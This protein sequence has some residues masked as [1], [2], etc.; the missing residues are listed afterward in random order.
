MMNIFNWARQ[1]EAI[2]FTHDLDFGALLK[3]THAEGPSVFQVRTQNVTVK[4]LKNMVITALNNYTEIL[5]TGALIII[6]EKKLRIR[7]LPL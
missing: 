1:N 4:H 2:V 7:I 6:D 5:K 3:Y